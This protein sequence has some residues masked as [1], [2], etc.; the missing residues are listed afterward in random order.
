MALYPARLSATIMVSCLAY[1]KT[2]METH[3][4]VRNCKIVYSIH[5]EMPYQPI[6]FSFAARI[7]SEHSDQIFISG[8]MGFQVA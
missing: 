5:R 2:D 8:E 4:A 6:T 3:E 7:C 1:V